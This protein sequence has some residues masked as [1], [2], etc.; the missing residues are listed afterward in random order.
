MQPFC[1]NTKCDQTLLLGLKVRN[2][3]GLLD[4]VR[5]VP[6]AAIYYHTHRFLQQHHYLSPEPPNDFA[7]WVYRTLEKEYEYLDS[8][9]HVDEMLTINE[10]EFTAEGKVA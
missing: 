2:I 5:R 9:E 6:D 4:G 7:H 3:P 10:Y 1:F 8:D